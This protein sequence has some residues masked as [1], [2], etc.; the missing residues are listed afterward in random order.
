MVEALTRIHK[1]SDL[2]GLSSAELE[3]LC[4]ELREMIVST[5]ALNGGHLAPNLGVVELTV[6]L[7]SVYNEPEDKIIWDV[8]HQ[9]YAH[10]LLTGRQASFSSLRMAGGLSG[11]PNPQESPYDYFGVGHSSTSIS[12]TVG[13]AI[14]RDLEHKSGVT[15]AIIGD[16]SLTA[17]V[18]FE[19]LNH[20]GQL[21]KQLVVV[22]NDNKMSISPN[23]G[24]LSMYLTRLRTS[25]NY[26]RL[27]EDIE[28]LLKR[29]PAIGTKVARTAERVKDGVRYMLIPGTL[30][31]ELG[32]TYF[33]PL[34]GHNISEL[35]SVFTH[36]RKVEGPVLVHVLTKKGK[37]YRPAEDNPGQFHGTG[38]FDISSGKPLGKSCTT[39]T[40]VFSRTMVELGAVHPDLVAVCAAMVFGTGLTEFS[41]C[42]PERV[43]DVG[44]AEQHAVTLAAALAAAGLRPVV[45]IYSTFLQRAYDQVVHDVCLQNL[46]VTFCIDRAGL[47]GQDGATHQGLFDLAYL[48]HIPNITVA[49]PRDAEELKQIL[50]C[51][52][53]YPGPVAIRYP[54]S[55]VEK[56][57][58]TMGKAEWGKGELLKKGTHG[59]VLAVG[60]MVLPCLRVAQAL[61]KRGLN[62]GV[63]DARFIKPLPKDLLL[64]LMRQ[65]NRVATV[66]EHALA[67]GFGSAVLELISDAGVDIDLKRFGIKDQFIEHANRTQQLE[68][69]GLDDESLRSSFYDFFVSGRAVTGANDTSGT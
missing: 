24:A 44:I 16:G 33:G 8:G 11:Y 38:P 47:V 59:L 5:V 63:C 50:T 52:V 37:G 25:P 4:R 61:E 60:S 30:F 35:Q 26:F 65:H 64:D 39:F 62:V 32:F 22:L 40:D 41:H 49:A 51:A 23:V 12:A 2:N 53:N 1:P 18:A 15:C 54:R 58:G 7:H 68:M 56:G 29:I 66:E 45:A 21:G 17:G 57:A 48:R 42:Y 69:C 13:Y 14:A 34:D 9:A 55:P 46:P 43:F 67:G 27:K 36:V 6:A 28:F 19:A 31:E 3:N 20:A 10:K